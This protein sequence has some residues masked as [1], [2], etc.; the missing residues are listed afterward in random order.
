MTDPQKVLVISS[1]AE[2][3]GVLGT[4]LR[5]CGMK[6]IVCESVRECRA[7]LDSGDVALVFCDSCVKDGD[8]REVMRLAAAS[9][10]HPPVVVTSRLDDTSQYLEA[11][12]LGAFDFVARPFRRSEIEWIVQNATR[13]TVVAA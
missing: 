8:Y 13:K 10:V 4:F 9:G 7:A 2:G 3:T 11:M 6:A 5:S 12:R 1:D